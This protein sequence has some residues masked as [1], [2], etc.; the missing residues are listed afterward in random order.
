MAR[1]ALFG[2]YAPSLYN[3]RGAL[4][5]ELARR[6]HRVFAVA[7]FQEAPPDMGDRIQALGAR[8]IPVS[9]ARTGMNPLED[10]KSFRELSALFQSLQLDVLLS[11][12]LKPVLYGSLA[13]RRAGVPRILGL[14]TGLGYSFSGTSWKQNLLRLGLN[15]L[16]R[17]ALEACEAVIFQ[18]PDDRRLFVERK[19]VTYEKTFR[20]WGSGVDLEHFSYVP[21][22]EELP[23]SFLLIARL[24]REKGI[25]EYAAAAESIGKRYPGTRCLLAGPFDPNPGGISRE[26]VESWHS[27]GILEYLGPLEDVRPSLAASSVYVLP[28]YREG[29]PRSSLEAMATGRPLI[30][31][32]VPGCRETLRDGYNGYLVP[33]RNGEALAEKMALFCDNP[34]LVPLLG[35]R[36]RSL[37]EERFCVHKVN[38][39][40]I[41]II[42]KGL[43]WGHENPPLP[44]QNGEEKE[45]NGKAGKEG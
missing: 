1:I 44:E 43:A 28:S 31:T 9:L 17:R 21:P 24:L 39:A 34:A 12:T 32:D 25:R 33:P 3:F 7:P 36:S 40:M 15:P 22:R 26:E 20:V 18:N 23:L 45:E 38:A 10:R 19:L 29:T 37:A 30:T 5:R 35:K 13:A 16:L 8:Y 27:R 2:G 11:Y 14:I 42:E 41:G 4:L 6:G